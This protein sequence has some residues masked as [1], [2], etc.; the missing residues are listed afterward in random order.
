MVDDDAGDDELG[1]TE[2]E[3]PDTVSVDYSPS[4]DFHFC[5]DFT[6]APD[7]VVR[8]A[9]QLG[10]LLADLIEM[11]RGFSLENGTE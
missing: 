11:L 7:G 5:L 1:R 9:D 4:R 6:E 3:P 8:A 2:P 10:H